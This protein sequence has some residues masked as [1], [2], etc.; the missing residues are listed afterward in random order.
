MWYELPAVNSVEK[1][2]GANDALYLDFG[3]GGR[4]CG[5]T[6]YDKT[7]E[8][9]YVLKFGMAVYKLVK[10]F[11]TSVHLT[12]DTDTF[13]SLNDR[14]NAMKKLSEKYS[15][16]EAYSF[17]CNA[18]NK[19]VNGSEMLLSIK[20]PEDGAEYEFCDKF[21]KDY[22]SLFSL[23]NRGVKQKKSSKGQDYYYL[24][25]STPTNVNMKYLELF[26]GDNRSDCKK[27]QSTAYFNKAVFMCAS[28]ILKRYD[29]TISKPIT[30]VE[31]LYRVQCGAFKEETNSAQLVVDLQNKGF[32]AIIKKEKI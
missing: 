4:D 1:V 9:D 13:V 3:H 20:E 19:S 32:E 5:C 31:Y 28:Y 8:K 10:P 17:H 23:V 25:R 30:T 26:F 7:Y 15:T 29:K 11:F 18:F 12:R 2:L 6:F 16:V 22:C 21:L 14:T 27:G 24:H